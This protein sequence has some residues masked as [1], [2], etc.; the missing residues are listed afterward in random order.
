M[1]SSNYE[2]PVIGMFCKEVAGELLAFQRDD[3]PDVVT[4]EDQAVFRAE[5]RKIPPL[6]AVTVGGSGGGGGGGG[7]GVL[8]GWFLLGGEMFFVCLGQGVIFIIR[9]SLVFS[10]V[11]VVH[12]SSCTMY[13][14]Y[15]SYLCASHTYLSYLSCHTPMCI[16]HAFLVV[17]PCASSPPMCIITNPHTGRNAVNAQ[18]GHSLVRLHPLPTLAAA[19][20]PQ[21]TAKACGG[22]FFAG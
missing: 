19:T 1:W 12:Y 6:G 3:E 22:G 4:E 21:G 15:H 18:V 8:G 5:G 9:I 14:P 2:V 16:I 11:I 20:A 10:F 17:P 7:G 13:C